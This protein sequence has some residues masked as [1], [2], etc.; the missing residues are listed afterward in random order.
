MKSTLRIAVT[1]ALVLLAPAASLTR[2]QVPPDGGTARVIVKYKADS[3]LLRKQALAAGQATE[4]PAQ[5]LGQ[6]VGMTLA[7]GRAMGERAQLV[8]AKGMSSAA[9]AERLA[10]EGDVEYAVPDRRKRIVAAPND[11]LYT[12]AP[13]LAAGQWYLR[14]NDANFPAAINAEGAWTTTTG[15]P[16]VVV[17]VVDTGIRRDHAD[18]AGRLLPGYDFIGEDTS[19]VFTTAGDGD[20][21]DADPS[22]PGDYVRSDPNSTSS[23]HGTQVSGLISAATNN[24]IGIASIGRNVSVLPVRALGVDGGYDSD[25]IDGMRWAAGLHVANVNDNPPANRAKVINL[26][27]GGDTDCTPLYR[28]V[29]T[30]LAA[31][32]V[33][34]VA[35]AGNSAGHAV[36][37]PANCPGVIGVAGLRHAGT[38]VGFSDIGPEISIS[39]PAG[40]CVND[41]TG[42]CLLPILT[43]SNS[44]S[45]TPV[46][47]LAGGS[48]YDGAIGTS[49]SAPMVAATAAL[50]LSANAALTPAAIRELIQTTARPF[51]TTGGGT[52]GTAVLA[53][54]ATQYDDA[55]RAIDQDECYC[56]TGT[57]GTGMLDVRAAVLAASTG[58][59]V[60]RSRARIDLS[61]A[62]PMAM[63]ALTVSGAQSLAASGRSIT[64]YR[65]SIVNG[66]GIVT[67]IANATASIASVTPTA[68]GRFA[69][70]L[71]VTDSSALTATADLTIVVGDA[72]P[73]PPPT[74]GGGGGGAL[75]ATWLLLLSGAL[76]ALRREAG[77]RGR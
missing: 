16:G 75:D 67:S 51:P 45:R 73:V 52:S 49:F 35:S 14:A 44:G 37:E 34:V 33:L 61:P 38:K 40:N 70:R 59:P 56:S 57:C 7:A 62:A 41:I 66:G 48:V 76:F 71:T 50:M 3:P 22:D 17:A 21:R 47:D 19:G 36:S 5:A 12:T 42:P 27:L 63:R 39:A 15:N 74:T 68:A 69:L 29:V 55:G 30:E 72:P 26:S 11:P 9:L 43:T 2:A 6:R 31:A 28:D 60:P 13:T 1:L 10:R 46:S 25:I 65:W 53:C 20:G 4:L 58:T 24:G 54:T 77:S 18:F 8:F 64:D 32:G 23:W